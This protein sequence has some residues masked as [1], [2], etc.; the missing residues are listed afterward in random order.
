M[1]SNI[2]ENILKDTLAYYLGL[3][4]NTLEK[5]IVSANTATKERVG[6]LNDLEVIIYSND[7]NPPH[8]HVKSKDL[9]IDA[10]FTIEQCDLISGEINSKYFKRIKT[11]YDSPKGKYI[12]EKIWNKRL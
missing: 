7:H 3:D 4:D 8:F 6:I 5:H 2:L 1:T 12:L 9:K 10:K 11:F